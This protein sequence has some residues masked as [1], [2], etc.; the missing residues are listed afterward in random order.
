MPL[1][2]KI[3]LFLFITA[4]MF[5][6]QF[7]SRWSPWINLV[8]SFLIVLILP[9]FWS[10]AFIGGI[11]A[12]CAFFTFHPE[13]EKKVD[14]PSS[15]NWKRILFCSLWTFS[16]FLLTL[17][18]I[19]K[20][21]VHT[22]LSTVHREIAARFFL[23]G[24]E[25]CLYKVITQISSRLHRIPLGY[26][27]AV[28]NFIMILYWLIHL[29]LFTILLTFMSLFIINPLL[30]IWPDPSMKTRDSFLGRNK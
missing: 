8:V 14:G 13:N 15:L 4:C 20:I 21:K 23:V 1:F 24:V 6:T 7:F 2:L 16:G 22:D 10:S 11:W 25:I 30:L 18:F 26:G 3:I 17:L 12:A 9:P 5:T 28:L 29:G 19:W 27:I